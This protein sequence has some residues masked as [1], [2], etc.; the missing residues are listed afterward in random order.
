MTVLLLDTDGPAAFDGENDLWI[1]IR[2]VDEKFWEEKKKNV[3]YGNS[4]VR[5]YVT[6]L[7]NT[8]LIH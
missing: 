2:A 4:I 3:L 6:S 7:V 1:V 5:N 8:T